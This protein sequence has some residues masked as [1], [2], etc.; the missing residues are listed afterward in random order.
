MIYD[1]MTAFARLG[2]WEERAAPLMKKSFLERISDL[3]LQHLHH[4]VMFNL[5]VFDWL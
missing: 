4:N 5:L 3:A 1:L 2:L